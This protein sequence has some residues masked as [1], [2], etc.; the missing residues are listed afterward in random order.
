[1][2]IWGGGISAGGSEMNPGSPPEWEK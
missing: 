1:V 2:A